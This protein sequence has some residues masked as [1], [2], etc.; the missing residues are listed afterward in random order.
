MADELDYDFLRDALIDRLPI[1][2]QPVLRI[3]SSVGF[4]DA[5]ALILDTE[6][7]LYFAHQHLRAP[8][9]SQ[10]G[11]RPDDLVRVFPSDLD[12]ETL[13]TEMRGLQPKEILADLR[14]TEGLPLKLR[15][16]QLA[17]LCRA[18]DPVDEEDD[19]AFIQA[20]ISPDFLTHPDAQSARDELLQLGTLA[21]LFDCGEYWYL[22]W[23]R[24]RPVAGTQLTSVPAAVRQALFAEDLATWDLSQWGRWV[25]LPTGRPWK[26]SELPSAAPN[27][28]AQSIKELTRLDPHLPSQAAAY[29][30]LFALE[31]SLYRL[32]Q[33]CLGED[34]SNWW[35]S[36]DEDVKK[37]LASE[38]AHTDDPDELQLGLSFSDFQRIVRSSSTWE[39]FSPSVDPSGE[40][41]RKKALSGME[42]VEAIRNRVMHPVRLLARP[43]RPR[44]L[45]LLDRWLSEVREMVSRAEGRQR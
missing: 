24:G 26:W 42:A 13:S 20:L 39:R 22:E 30:R 14:S 34:S 11:I 29:M 28:V 5:T 41:G 10:T 36:L 15:A 43:V 12:A 2:V 7:A 44:D 38:L 1:D 31:L 4:S 37:R 19:P 16:E 6:L 33:L 32:V 9:G 3:Y 23:S 35:A 27:L 8:G 40:V 21:E 17:S 18:L 45:E 25:E